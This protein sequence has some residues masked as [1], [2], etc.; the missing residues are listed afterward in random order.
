[1]PGIAYAPHWYDGITLSFQRYLPWVGVDTTQTNMRFAFGRGKRRALFRE[2]MRRFVNRSRERFGQAPV[3]IGET[4]ISFNLEKGRAYRDGNFAQ[5][6]AALD[7]V[8][9][10]LEST[11]VDFTLWDYT[12][13]NTNQHGDQWN[14]EDLS[15]FSR[16]QRQLEAGIHSGG[17]ALAAAIRPYAARIPGEALEQSFDLS[18]GIYRLRFRADPSVQAPLEVFVPQYHY[19]A[20][21]IV[22]A[23]HGRVDLDLD[24]QRLQYWP[25]AGQPV[26]EV[27]IT[28]G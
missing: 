21:A 24:A 10:A 16:D 3:V 7:D 22:I 4:G 18:T 11:G 5:Q 1:L 2:V 20:G 14:G 19:A 9:Q 13:D 17:R 8:M 23:P 12:A 26:H 15:I 6:V 27:E 25:A 28:K